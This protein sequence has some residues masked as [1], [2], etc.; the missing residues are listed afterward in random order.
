MEPAWLTIARKEIGTVEGPGKSNNPKVLDYF[1]E[2]AH[3]E[4]HGD[5]TAWCAGFCGAMLKRA[6]IKPS[7]SLAARS[8]ESWGSPLKSPILGAVAVKKRPGSSWSGHVGFVVGASPTQIF[9]LGGNQADRV[10]IAAFRRSEFTA[11]RW[12]A[13]IGVPTPPD[14]LP[15][16]IAGAKINP[17]QT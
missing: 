11:F 12:P 6:G 4:I 1:I 16:T 7:G 10:S 8:Y 2:A 3:P 14:P 15:S 13:N 9:L 5:D 17:K